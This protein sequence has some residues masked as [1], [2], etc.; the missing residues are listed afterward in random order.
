MTSSGFTVVVPSGSA[1]GTTGSTTVASKWGPAT[2]NPGQEG[3]GHAHVLALSPASRWNAR[4]AGTSAAKP[5][6]G[7]EIGRRRRLALG[8][9][10]QLSARVDDAI[11]RPP[12]R[13]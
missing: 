7:A 3:L 2:C 9:T 12:R 5:P 6:A 10:Q 11:G 1:R 8:Q 4:G 13:D